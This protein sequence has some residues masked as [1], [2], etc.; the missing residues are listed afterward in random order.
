[1]ARHYYIKIPLF[2]HIKIKCLKTHL[3]QFIQYLLTNPL[4]TG[5]QIA[6]M[7]LPTIHH[8]LPIFTTIHTTPIQHTILLHAR[9]LKHILLSWVYHS[10][11]I[12]FNSI[13][14]VHTVSAF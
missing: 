9:I 8:N 12:I 4:N 3:N 7:S 6:Y 1:M 13:V 2:S 5:I 11:L 10:I 14:M